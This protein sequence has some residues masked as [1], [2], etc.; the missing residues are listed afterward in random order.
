MDENTL[1]G[2]Y[3]GDINIL[4]DEITQLK[5]VITNLNDIRLGK[6]GTRIVGLDGFPIGE[7]ND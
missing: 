4:C 1:T 6:G 7:S 3:C 5:D 2:E